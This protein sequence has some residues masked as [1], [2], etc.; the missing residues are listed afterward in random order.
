[1][2]RGI[3][4][5]TALS[6]SFIADAKPGIAKKHRVYKKKNKRLSPSSYLTKLSRDYRMGKVAK[7]NIWI[8]LQNFHTRYKKTS[9]NLRARV[10]QSQAQLL[11]DD[12]YPLLAA[13]YASQAIMTNPKPHDRY[14]KKSWSMLKK[15]SEKTPI[16]NILIS[17]AKN[18]NLQNKEA[19]Y[20]KSG[21][22]YYLGSVYVNSNKEKAIKYFSKVKMSD[23]N[24]LASKYSEAMARVDLNQLKKAQKILDKIIYITNQKN[25][26]PLPKAALKEMNNLANLAQGRIYYE[27]KQFDNS[28]KSYRHVSKDSVYYY[29]ALF[30]Q[31]WAFFMSGY[32]NH[33]LGALHS[34]ESPFF[35]N[36]YNPEAA[37]LK[38]LVYYWMCQYDD[39]RISLAAFNKKY[40]KSIDGLA[41]VINRKILREQTSYQLFENYISGVSG[42]SLGIPREILEVAASSDSLKPLRDQY[43][44]I[45][46]EKTKL[47]TKGIYRTLQGSNKAI[48]FLEKWESSLKKGIGKQ[49]YAELKDI[50]TAYDQLHEQAQFLEIELLMSEKDHLLGK[51]LHASNKITRV[52]KKRDVKGWGLDQSM[53]WDNS[54]KQEYWWDEI[55]Y[56]IYK[57]EPKCNVK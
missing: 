28:F 13:V 23:Y 4:I 29:D 11:M 20:F 25:I 6:L 57:V 22:N 30:E 16:Q 18:V 24:Y 53:S 44:T 40:K 54:S 26:T 34:L 50:K 32:P 7:K 46:E 8:S 19:P 15:I 17:L 27:S 35:S 36:R 52:S 45:V 3:I 51:E 37:V 49:F 47:N 14:I 33:A 55:G 43:A 31:S 41:S 56:Y 12:N 2:F 42:A 39:S 1:M 5:V 48:S 9:K 10:L 38:S 21:W